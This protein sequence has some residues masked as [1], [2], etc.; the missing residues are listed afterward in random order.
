MGRHPHLPYRLP[1]RDAKGHGCLDQ[2]ADPARVGAQSP[3]R[4][5]AYGPH[6]LGRA[7]GCRRSAG[8]GVRCRC[9]AGGEGLQHR[10]VDEPSIRACSGQSMELYRAIMFGPSALTR[11]ERELLA[12]VG[13]GH[14]RVPLLTSLARRR[15]PCRGRTNRAG[16]PRGARLPPG[17]PRS[18]HAGTV[19]LRAAS[20]RSNLRVSVRRTW[21]RCRFMA[22]GRRDPRR[23]PGDRLLQL[24]QPRGRGRRNR[25]RAR[26]GAVRLRP[27]RRRVTAHNAS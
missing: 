15:P 4:R 14:Q 9:S 20:S 19:R 5:C 24:H 10:Q 11:Q 17:R 18:P 23:D 7:G 25:P 3:V 6:P 26:V 27:A 22:C 13:L 12:T 1:T 8:R 21:L 2:D 16:R